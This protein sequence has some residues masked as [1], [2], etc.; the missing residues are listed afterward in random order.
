MVQT[1]FY[2]PTRQE[3]QEADEETLKDFIQELE[4]QK[5]DLQ[6]S[7]SEVEA[8]LQTAQHVLAERVED[9]PVDETPDTDTAIDTE[10]RSTD[11]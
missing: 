9:T 11:D 3:Y 10:T 4:R 2:R 5:A 8:E 6:E 7:I 1:P